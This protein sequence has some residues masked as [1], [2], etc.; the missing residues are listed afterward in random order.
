MNRSEAGKLGGIKSSEITK[1]KHL[2]RIEKYNSNPKLCEE[3]AEPISYEKKINKF[4]NQSCSAKF[5]N[6]PRK[7]TGYC[8]Y[9]SKELESKKHRKTYCSTSC[10]QALK[11]ENSL[12][13]NKISS[14]AIKTFLVKKYGA[15]CMECGWSKENPFTKTIPI[16]LEHID[17][18]SENNTLDNVKL[19]CPSCHS[20][21]PTYKGAN[22][23]KGRYKRRER[24]RQGKSY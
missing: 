18:N 14:K 20:L 11:R 21:T 7:I 6:R 9:C 12:K 22:I 17:G 19:L 16:E 4:C 15:I 10:Q 24:Y 8:L 13:D 1:Q 5:Y 3:C 23:G 2:E